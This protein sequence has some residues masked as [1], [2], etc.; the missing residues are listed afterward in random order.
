[1]KLGARFCAPQL[2]KVTALYNRPLPRLRSLLCLVQRSFPLCIGAVPN[3]A[4]S[5]DC[6]SDFELSIPFAIEPGCVSG[7]IKLLRNGFADWA[8]EHAEARL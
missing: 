8:K 2:S 7:T 4:L 5:K 1:M 3:A 6:V